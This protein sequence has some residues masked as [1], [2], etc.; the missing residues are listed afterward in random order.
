MAIVLLGE[1]MFQKRVLDIEQELCSI[2][3]DELGF[4]SV[5]EAATA[6]RIFRESRSV[7]YDVYLKNTAEDHESFDEFI[8]W[9]KTLIN[10]YNEIDRELCDTNS[11][12]N[13][14]KAFKDLTHWSNYEKQTD[15]IKKYKEF[16]RKIKLYHKDLTTRL[17]NK[18]KAYQ[19]LIYREAFERMHNYIE[20]SPTQKHIFIGFNALSK[21]EAEVIQEIINYNGEIY[22]DIDKTFLKSD[23]NNASLFIESY[24]SKWNY[25]KKNKVK[26]ISDSYR[27][28]KNIF[29]P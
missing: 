6:F 19:G 24:L 13:Y 11:L 10:D 4:L 12:F 23:F 15:L 9:A 5:S 29:L 16:W 20:S 7:F 26:I 14:L 1:Q 18:R 2:P 3:F 22:W 17:F 8:S 21:S 28:E 27:K 25:Y